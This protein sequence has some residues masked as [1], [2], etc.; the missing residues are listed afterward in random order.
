MKALT[1]LGFLLAVVPAFA[2][3]KSPGSVVP[4]SCAA[5]VRS[6]AGKINVCYASVVGTSGAYI[7]I[8]NEVW[9]LTPNRR[10]AVVKIE[11]VGTNRNGH[12]ENRLTTEIRR[13]ELKRLNNDAVE[14]S[15][16]NQTIYAS[17][18]EVVFTTLSH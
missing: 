14:I 10:G 13:G 1:V 12:L 2:E 8:A 4:T 6:S 18:F 9:V 16:Q 3:M 17:K 15:V 11:H 7:E 5:E